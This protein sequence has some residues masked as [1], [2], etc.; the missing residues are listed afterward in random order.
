MSGN[1]VVLIP[2]CCDD[3]ERLHLGHTLASLA[4]QSIPVDRIRVIV[5][6]EGRVPAI[7]ARDVRLLMDLLARRSMA[8]SYLRATDRRGIANARRDL[9]AR[10]ADDE[11]LVLF[12]DDDMILEPNCLAELI[13]VHRRHPEAGFVQGAKIEIDPRRGYLNDINT[14]RDQNND[15]PH[16]AVFGDAALLLL[17]ADALPLIDWEIVA[18]FSCEGLAGEDVA[19]TLMIADKRPGLGVPRARAWHLSPSRERWRWE[20]ASDLLRVHLLRNAVSQ[21][22]LIAA[23]PHLEAEIRHLAKDLNN[24]ESVPKRAS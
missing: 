14:V 15:D 17:P 16:P 6:D 19:M 18:Q 11:S 12:I 22:T 24:D 1:L 20:P 10:V 9:I 2:T 7:G 4:T 23:L 13:A 21:P 8:P 5:R 3:P